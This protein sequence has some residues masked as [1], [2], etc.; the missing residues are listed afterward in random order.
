MKYI[1][2]LLLLTLFSQSVLASRFYFSVAGRGGLGKGGSVDG[3]ST[4]TRDLYVFGADATLGFMLGGVMIGGNAEYNIWK[5]KTDVD[6]VGGTNISGSQ[7]SFSPAIA[8]PFGR[9]MFQVKSPLSSTFTMD[10]KSSAGEKV[11]Y[12]E[13]NMPPYS[14]TLAYSLGRSYIGLEYT[15]IEY[16]KLSHGGDDT[17][18]DSDERLSLSSF[19]VVYGYKF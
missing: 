5:Q 16:K 4:E 6:E 19:G 18:L 17:T 12:S 10:R 3:E 9:F 1:I 8:I 14:L 13:P 11:K 2:T 7:I 15:K